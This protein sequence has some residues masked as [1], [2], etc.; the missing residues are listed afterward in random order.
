MVLDKVAVGRLLPKDFYSQDG[1]Q[2]AAPSLVAAAGPAAGISSRA[3]SSFGLRSLGGK[4]KEF[5]LSPSY[6]CFYVLEHRVQT[7]CLSI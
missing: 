1:S 7:L 3:L 2:F 6:I 4:Q 5:F